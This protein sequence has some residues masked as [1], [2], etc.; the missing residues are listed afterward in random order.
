MPTPRPSELQAWWG[1]HD[2]T[3]GATCMPLIHAPTLHCI[4][5]ASCDMCVFGCCCRH[6]CTPRPCCIA[7][8]GPSAMAA[9][10]QSHMRGCCRAVFQIVIGWLGGEG[11]R[12]CQVPL[13]LYPRP[14]GSAQARGAPD[15]ASTVAT[16]WGFMGVC[17]AVSSTQPCQ[18][19]SIRRA[20]TA[21]CGK[22]CT[23]ASSP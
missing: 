4:Q 6:T 8:E 2:C 1:V 14:S 3:V 21:L 9:P 18:G 15:Q 22:G 12:Y 7:G 10:V 19:K 23:H 17:R 20:C 11:S 5:A 13:T 16:C